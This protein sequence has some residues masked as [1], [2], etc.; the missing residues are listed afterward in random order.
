MMQRQ[1]SP[2]PVSESNNYNQHVTLDGVSVAYT[3]LD[4]TQF[5][6]IRDLTF[7]C[8]KR[9][10][11]SIIG[12]SGCG[13][14]TLLH[15]VAGFVR[16]IQG[17]ARCNGEIIRGPG[18][19]R[20][21]VFQQYANLPWRTVR[22]NIALGLRLRGSSRSEIDCTV[23]HYASLMGLEDFIDQFPGHL[24]GG[25]QQRVAIARA[26]ANEPAILLLDE[27][28]GALDAQTSE[29]LQEHLAKICAERP[30]TVLHVTHNIAEAIFLADRIVVV[31]GPPGRIVAVEDVALAR[32]RSYFELQDHPEFIRL[33]KGLRR[34]LDSP[35]DPISQ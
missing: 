12:P 30:L 17:T 6:A 26:L 1:A 13:K 9:E 25:M 24:S 16:P 23:Q 21:I 33:V 29:K 34:I 10:F 28:F 2:Q 27:P 35:S 11:V 32:P 20:G 8:A 7:Q 15:T 5:L 18:R 3:R 19:D 4:G 22:E 31:K 14:S